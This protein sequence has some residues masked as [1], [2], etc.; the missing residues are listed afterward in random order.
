[1]A[2]VAAGANPRPQLWTAVGGALR[3]SFGGWGDDA[4]GWNFG[5]LLRGCHPLFPGGGK[6]QIGEGERR[7]PRERD[8]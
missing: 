4:R 7:V 5:S 8:E 2:A 3:W 6:Q 1:M